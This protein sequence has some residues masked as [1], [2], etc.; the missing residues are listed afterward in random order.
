MSRCFQGFSVGYCLL[1]V[2]LSGVFRD[3]WGRGTYPPVLPPTAQRA[4]K[5]LDEILEYQEPK[6]ARVVTESK[7]IILSW[8]SERRG[9]TLGCTARKWQTK[10]WALVQLSKAL[11]FLLL[12]VLTCQ[13]HLFH[14]GSRPIM[15]RNLW[16]CNW[17]FLSVSPHWVTITLQKTF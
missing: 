1:L 14:Q 3:H 8:S 16:F 4:P 9:F 5:L 13:A 10:A 7:V 15:K 2:P 12:V 17:S 6:G 11:P